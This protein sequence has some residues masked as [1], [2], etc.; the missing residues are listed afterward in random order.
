MMPGQ[1]P[2]TAAELDKLERL[3]SEAA[4]GDPGEDYE[5]ALTKSL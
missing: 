1:E 2:Y 3:V 4:D 5:D